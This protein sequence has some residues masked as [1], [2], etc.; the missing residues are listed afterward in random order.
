MSARNWKPE[1]TR[2]YRARVKRIMRNCGAAGVYELERP[3][4]W[5][6]RPDASKPLLHKGRKP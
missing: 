2:A 1:T 3:A 4:M 6:L 5:C